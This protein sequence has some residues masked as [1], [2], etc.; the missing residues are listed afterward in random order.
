[1]GALRARPMADPMTPDVIAAFETWREPAYHYAIA[2]WRASKF[3]AGPTPN[4]GE[5]TRRC[6]P[7]R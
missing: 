1:M 2:I 7:P 5:S 3:G 6:R 4:K